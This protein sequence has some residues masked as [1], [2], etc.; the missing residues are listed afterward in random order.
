MRVFPFKYSLPLWRMW[1]DSNMHFC[2]MFRMCTS[3]T[4][5][6][7][8]KGNDIQVLTN[9]TEGIR[10]VVLLQERHASFLLEPLFSLVA[11]VDRF[12]HALLCTSLT[13]EVDEQGNDLQ[14]HINLVEGVRVVVILQEL[15]AR[16]LLKLLFF[17]VVSVDRCKHAIYV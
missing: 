13:S 12:K 15:H 1:A 7:D 5:E 14:V 6:D 10:V 2:L 17:L 11:R 4:S 3:L 9:L 8:E 16:L